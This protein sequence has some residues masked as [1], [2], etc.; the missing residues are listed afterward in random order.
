MTGHSLTRREAL[1]GIGAAGAAAVGGIAVTQRVA[2]TDSGEPELTI[3][4]TIPSGTSIDAMVD[5][6]DTSDS[7]TPIN[8]QTVT[9][10]NS[11]TLVYD[12]LEGTGDY[13][14]EFTLDF[15]ADGD[16]TPELETPL[17]FEV[18]PPDPEDFE[19]VNYTTKKEWS[20]K[21]DDAKIVWDEYRLRQFQ[22]LLKMDDA[23]RQAFDGLY[24]YV[25]TS[26]DQDTDVLCYWSK[27]SSGES[28]PVGDNALGSAIGDHDP[29]YV[30]VNSETDE[31]E[32]IVYSG[33]NLE[34][35]EIQPSEDDLEQRRTDTPTHA[36]FTVVSGWNHYRHTPDATGHF[37]E[38]KSWGEVRETWQSNN[39]GPD[40]TAVENPWQLATA[41]DWRDND[42]VF[43]LTDIWLNLG[44]Q[45]GW[46]GADNIDELRE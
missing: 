46:Y 30:F 37:A 44:Q 8:S 21:P 36:T 13:Y 32:R 40:T 31:L 11:G 4:G 12:G 20:A 18:P 19:F 29:I 3:N 14:Y 25:A 41:S 27:V 34:A 43:S 17:V 10:D 23:T 42:G 2:A 28:L 35:A 24:G 38:L 15:S 22:P 9:A 26:E 1:L 45:I 6:Y 33:Y 16:S 39:F 7:S 5:E